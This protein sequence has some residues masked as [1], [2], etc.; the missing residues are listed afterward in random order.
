MPPK[1]YM[2]AGFPPCIS[3]MIQFNEHANNYQ[4]VESWLKQEEER[5]YDGCAPFDWVSPEER[6]RAI[7]TDSVW[8]C[9]WYISTPIGS[10]SLAASTFE[11]LMAGVNE[12]RRS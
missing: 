3:L 4:T 5:S 2:N 7:K 8:V 11:T 12:A 6:E 10:S 1:V 9:Q